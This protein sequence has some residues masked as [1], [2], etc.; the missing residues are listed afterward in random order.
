MAATEFVTPHIEAKKGDFAKTVL[1]PGDPKRAE[2]IAKNFFADARLVNDIRGVKGYTGLYKGKRAS[3]MASG[4]GMPSIGIYSYELYKFFDV[5]NI[6][7]IGSAGSMREDI[8]VRDLVFAMATSTNSSFGAQYALPGIYAPCADFALLSRALENAKR[9]GA[10]T[11]VGNVLSADTYYDDDPETLSKWAKMGVMAVE[12]EAAALYMTAA[13]LGKRA[14]A[15][16]TVSNS[17]LTGEEMPVEDR[18]RT[19]TQMIE[20]A[21]DT[22]VEFE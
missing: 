4:M 20:T 16:C 19:L 10:T 9:L 13:R 3:V 21:L 22:A 14:L 6:I 7:R 12:M 17:I 11:H 18:E 15:L 8:K 2:F 5:E 1:M